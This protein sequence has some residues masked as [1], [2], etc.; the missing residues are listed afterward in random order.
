V[1]RTIAGRHNTSVKLARRLLKKKYRRERGLFLSEGLDLLRV[2][3]EAGEQPVE[4]LVREDLVDALPSDLLEA[5]RDD[6]LDVGVCTPET[7]SLASSLGGA[8]DVVAIFEAPELSLR[9]VSLTGG[10]TV[11]L[12]GLGDPGNVGTII[13][14]AVSFGA[15]GV[16]CSPETA[17][18]FSP[19]AI[20]AGMGAQFVEPV[21]MDVTADQLE[22]KLAADARR[23]L[24]S[25][26]LLVADPRGDLPAHTLGAM[27][28]EEGAVLIMGSERGH[29][30]TLTR[31]AHHVVIPQAKF[32]SLNVAMAAT[33]LLYEI[34]KRE[35]AGG[36]Q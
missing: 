19:K 20:R 31:A 1:L 10:T 21:V 30:P 6:E 16:I 33:I 12:A 27:V 17:D 2:A 14:A 34:A 35:G 4:V 11:F 5:A 23:G 8:V 3:V 26:A 25:P 36:E 32:D 15:G 28:G 24:P 29:L 22:A 13:R 7:L 9:D 18:P